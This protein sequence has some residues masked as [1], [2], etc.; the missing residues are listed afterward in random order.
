MTFKVLFVNEDTI[1]TLFGLQGNAV[2]LSFKGVR[3]KET[4]KDSTRR[5]W[6]QLISRVLKFFG[7]DLTGGNISAFHEEMKESMFDCDMFEI[8]GK[9]V[10]V[11]PSINAV[12][13]EK[14]RE[15]NDQII[16]RYGSI[17]VDFKDIT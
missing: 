2:K 10:I 17:G 1:A 12:A 11:V 13:D 7:V 9:K 16:S 14:V 3:Y 6:F 5:R 8:D 4:V 15:A